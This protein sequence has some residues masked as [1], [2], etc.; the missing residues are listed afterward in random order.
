MTGADST[1][2]HCHPRPSRPAPLSPSADDESLPPDERAGPPA[3]R[4]TAFVRFG[5]MLDGQRAAPE[6]VV[7]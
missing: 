7:D 1:T 3:G 2:S 4:P 6:R 5:A